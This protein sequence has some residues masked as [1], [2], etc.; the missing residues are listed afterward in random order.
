MAKLLTPRTM[1]ALVERK[2]GGIERRLKRGDYVD[3]IARDLEEAARIL[4]SSQG[5]FPRFV[6]EAYRFFSENDGSPCVYVFWGHDGPLYIGQTTDAPRRTK[7]HALTAPWFNK[8]TK[9]VYIPCSAENLL[10]K[11]Q[12]LIRDLNPAYNVIRRTWK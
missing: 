6:Q 7:E 9:V 2:V 10:D 1:A 3:D 8:A 11:E 12:E 5:R 4:R